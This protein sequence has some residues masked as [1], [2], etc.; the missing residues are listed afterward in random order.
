MPPD[1][2]ELEARIAECDEILAS[3]DGADSES[4]VRIAK[5]LSR[6]ADALR[7][8]GRNAEAL[9]C[10]EEIDRGFGHDEDPELRPWAAYALGEKGRELHDLD[11]PGD[12]DRA[13]A[14]LLARFGEDESEPVAAEVSRGLYNRAYFLEGDG[15]AAEALRAVNM[16]LARYQAEPPAGRV[17][18]VVRALSVKARALWR[19]G[20]HDEAFAT[21]RNMSERY[22]EEGDSQVR[23]EVIRAGGRAAQLASEQG[24]RELALGLLDE[25][26]A[27]FGDSVEDEL[28]DEVT[29]VLN[30]KATVLYE[31]G[32]YENARGAWDQVVERCESSAPGW[33]R[34]STAIN[35]RW[36]ACSA[37]KKLHR[38]SEATER[39]REL[40]E[41][42]GEDDDP[43]VR[44]AVC[45]TIALQRSIALEEGRSED[46]IEFDDQLIERARPDDD[47]KMRWRTAFALVD[48]THQL[49]SIGRLDQAIAACEQLIGRLADERDE[50]TSERIASDVI[51]A[52]RRLFGSVIPNPKR[53]RQVR[54]GSRG[55]SPLVLLAQRRRALEASV[56]LLDATIEKLRQRDEPNAQALVISAKMLK[57]IPLV[58]LG[59][60][61]QVS[62]A[63]H[64]MWGSG[65]AGISGAEEA[66]RLEQ[67]RERP[68]ARV[69]AAFLMIRWLIMD[70]QG[71][72]AEAR[73]AQAE[74][75]ERFKADPSPMARLMAHVARSR[76]QRP[77]LKSQLKRLLRLGG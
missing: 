45:R 33:W 36:S 17:D 38:P 41:R 59:R 60:R 43:R 8:L 32:S 28:A 57:P 48:K 52:A 61:K 6:K 55:R 42:Y 21:Y 46:A 56:R 4:R 63:V 69:I 22:G 5:A 19:L 50:D 10:F 31:L 12:A 29:Y 70:T 53:W 73:N 23:L 7:A 1:H 65:A 74:L 66:A 3:E 54:F 51:Y 75:F 9:A 67:G 37:L 24:G 30:G 76:P 20:R 2:D 34:R 47:P 18:R 26:L 40:V 62:V 15:L 27:R 35:A 16:Y 49:A 44:E 68:H 14:E 64:E 13:F 39:A 25:L 72:K 71:R 58:L 11:R 77:G